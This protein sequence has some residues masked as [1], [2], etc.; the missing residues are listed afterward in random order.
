[1]GEI[2]W[3]SSAPG[4]CR[5]V[6]CRVSCTS[7]R[8]DS[9]ESRSLVPHPIVT[10]T[11]VDAV[12][13]VAVAPVRRVGMGW[14]RTL[15]R[16]ALRLM[17]AQMVRPAQRLQ[18]S[19]GLVAA[20]VVDVVNV[21]GR[22][23]AVG[24][25]TGGRRAA[26]PGPVVPPECCGCVNN[27]RGYCGPNHVRGDARRNTCC[28]SV[29]CIRSAHMLG[30]RVDIASSHFS[31][32]GM[33]PTNRTRRSTHR[34]KATSCVGRAAWLVGVGVVAVGWCA[35]GCLDGARC[36]A[37]LRRGVVTV[38]A[39]PTEQAGHSVEVTNDPCPDPH[40]LNAAQPLLARR[41]VAVGQVLPRQC[42]A[43]VRR[44]P[45]RFP[46]GALCHSMTAWSASSSAPRP[47]TLRN[48]SRWAPRT[49]SGYVAVNEAGGP[50]TP[51]TLYA[52]V[53]QAR[54]VSWGAPD[55]A[56]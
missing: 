21:T 34:C 1:M 11:I 30:A 50:Y 35:V 26:A 14:Y 55:P 4:G 20:L 38:E 37:C 18:R 16:P 47:A 43:V 25:D 51:D 8:L 53:A 6:V 28:V 46:R 24:V 48:A 44:D 23:V 32:V 31:A 12:A 42:S 2:T 19:V 40:C 29:V 41:G 36:A 33:A 15:E 45:K 5:L 49:D 17:T 52:D 7:S 22:R 9:T 54:Q 27:P 3:L 39:A 13:V 10:T 56:A